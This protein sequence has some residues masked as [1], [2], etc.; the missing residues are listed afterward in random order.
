MQISNSKE[1]YAVDDCT[2]LSMIMP[3]YNAV[4]TISRSVNSFLRLAAKLLNNFDINCKLYIIDDCSDDGT[5]QIVSDLSQSYENIFFIRNNKNI[6]PGFSR[7]KALRLS[8]NGYIG[9]LDADDEI[10]VDGYIQSYIEGIN[11]GADWITSNG[12]FFGKDTKDSRYDFERLVDDTEQLSIRCLK[13]ELDGSVIFSVY[14]SSLIHNNNL[15]FPDGYYEDISFAYEAMLLSKNRYIS[16]NFSYKKHNVN[17]SIV[18]TMSEKHIKGFISA[19]VRV[20]CILQD[21]EL[22]DFQFDRLYGLYG[23]IANLITSIILSDHSY[24][25][26]MNLLILLSLEID[27]KV[28]IYKFNYNVETKKDKLVKYFLENFSRDSDTFVSDIGFFYHHLFDQ[29]A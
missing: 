29:D 8:K 25:Y 2:D 27:S 1:I 12:W 4:Y 19:W 10:I 14:S 9:F 21:Y 28:E 22:S 11:L 6:G 16:K 7:N 24:H 23:Y 17:I 13:G 5:T 18:N 26:K 20:D 15:S 3:V